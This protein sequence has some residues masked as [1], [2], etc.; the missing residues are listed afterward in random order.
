MSFIK[1]LMLAI[2]L[3]YALS[4]FFWAVFSVFNLQGFIL[5][6]AVCALAGA[7]IG[8]LTGRRLVVTAI[9]TILIRIAAYLVAVSA[10]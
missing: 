4:L 6:S 8:F 3:S 9:A 2:G 5:V 1:H 7:G 10:A